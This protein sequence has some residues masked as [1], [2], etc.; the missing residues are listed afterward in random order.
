[1]RV[2]KQGEP[3]AGR[4]AIMNSTDALHPS[5]SCN[6]PADLAKPRN[7]LAQSYT[8]EPVVTPELCLVQAAE[9][10]LSQK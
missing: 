2:F 9:V 1:M 7:G 3:P 10:V 6:A 8:A 4:Q 5:T